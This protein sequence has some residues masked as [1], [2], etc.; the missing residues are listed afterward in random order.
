[1]GKKCSKKRATFKPTLTVAISLPHTTTGR[2]ACL[3]LN[4]LYNTSV[5]LTLLSQL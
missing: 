2:Q 4:K 3:C 5:I 1:M